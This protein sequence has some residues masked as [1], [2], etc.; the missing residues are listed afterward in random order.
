MGKYSNINFIAIKNGTECPK[1][2]NKNCG[3][4][5]TLNQQL[6]IKENKK[7]NSG[8]IIYYKQPKVYF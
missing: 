5:D 7:C 8:C 3:R 4:I 6:C 2:Y 1:E